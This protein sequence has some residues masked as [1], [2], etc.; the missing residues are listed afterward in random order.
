MKN[1]FYFLFSV[2]LI[3][4]SCSSDDN[5]EETTKDVDYKVKVWLSTIPGSA[6]AY[7]LH[8]RIVE[9]W[10]QK[11]G[12]GK[13]QTFVKKENTILSITLG[14]L[15]YVKDP[16]LSRSPETKTTFAPWAVADDIPFPGNTTKLVLIR[17]G[18]EDIYTVEI[19]SGITFDPQH[20]SFSE[21]SLSD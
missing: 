4:C 6:S 16:M 17:K 15:E 8:I 1:L 5:D 12:L 11:E 10:C 21:F 9:D 7:I 19:S 18:V 14:D 3:L 20:Q 13:I 2:S